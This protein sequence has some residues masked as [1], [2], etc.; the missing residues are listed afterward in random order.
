MNKMENYGDPDYKQFLT[1]HTNNLQKC[2]L[3]RR[4]IPK[5]LKRINFEYKS[6]Y[7]YS[8]KRICLYCIKKLAECE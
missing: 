5:E 3:C 2:S 1:T 7:G 8:Y 4:S 6:E